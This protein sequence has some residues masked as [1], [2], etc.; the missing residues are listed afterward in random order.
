MLNFSGDALKICKSLI[1]VNTFKMTIDFY[2]YNCLN[3]SD[4]EHLSSITLEFYISL[5]NNLHLIYIPY[6]LKNGR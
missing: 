3:I 1:F 2:T 4:I 6:L 5:T